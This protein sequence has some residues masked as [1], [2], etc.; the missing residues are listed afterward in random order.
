M[1]LKPLADHLHQLIFAR[2]AR[3]KYYPILKYRIH[4]TVNMLLLGT[5]I[6]V[7]G[8]LAFIVY[9]HVYYKLKI[10][11]MNANSPSIIGDCVRNIRSSI[12]PPVFNPFFRNV[13]VV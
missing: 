12:V 1:I 3:H 13:E 5:G 11:V 6:F 7:K 9:D 10:P 8:Y 4:H 2:Y